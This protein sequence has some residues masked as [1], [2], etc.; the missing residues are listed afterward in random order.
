LSRRRASAHQ[1]FFRRT[2]LDAAVPTPLFAQTAPQPATPPLR[3][4]AED[5]RAYQG[6]M[7]ASCIVQP[8]DVLTC[9][10]L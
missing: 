5:A 6:A 1:A 2:L 8:L 7:A 3:L 10:A 9:D 4:L